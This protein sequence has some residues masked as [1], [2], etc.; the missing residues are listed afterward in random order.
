[1]RIKNGFSM[2][3]IMI[4]SVIIGILA[5]LGIGYYTTA[6]ENVADR[7]AVSN[8]KNIYVAEKSYNLDHNNYYPDLVA[9]GKS[10]ES[11]IGTI[12]TKLKLSLPTATIANRNWD[13]IVYSTGCARATRNGGDVRSWF[14]TIA[15]GDGTGPG[16]DGEPNSG[17]G[18]P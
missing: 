13:Y 9:D 15:D 2:M 6:K 4:V 8:L 12:N 11:D 17:V 10:S 5:T 1:M 16:S 18:C 7:E 3:E 14:F